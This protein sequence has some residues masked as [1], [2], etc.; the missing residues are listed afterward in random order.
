MNY[1]QGDEIRRSGDDENRN[2]AAGGLKNV[3][4]QR[5]DYQPADRPE[6]GD[7]SAWSPRHRGD[8]PDA[9]TPQLLIEKTVQAF[10]R[11]G[12]VVNNAGT[13]RRA[14][15]VDWG[16]PEDLAGA[17]VFLASAASNYINGHVLVVDGGWLAL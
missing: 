13:I 14:A 15:A 1:K 12:I 11:L 4:D 3:A 5:S 2:R 8:V 10:G 9:A 7:P 16:R 6:L 17:A